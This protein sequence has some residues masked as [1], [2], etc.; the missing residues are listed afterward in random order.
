[1]RYH[2]ISCTLTEFRAAIRLCP[3]AGPCSIDE[4]TASELRD[5]CQELQLRD[6]I[7][8]ATITGCD[9]QFA[10]GR[11]TPPH[12]SA[13]PLPER[14]AWLETMGVAHSIAVLPM[15][16]IAILNGDAIA[17]GLELALATDLRIAADRALFGAG[18]LVKDGFPYDGASQRL[19]RLVGP[20]MALDLLLTGRV[21]S[22]PEALDAGL[23]NRVVP[24]AQLTAAADELTDSITS[25]APIA[26]RYA[27]EAV[28]AAADLTLAQ[29]LRLEADLSIILHSTADRAEGLASF[30]EKRPA[31]FAG[32]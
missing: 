6:E 16:V 9:D 13:A 28:A 20:A 32:R 24:A 10:V 17:H 25:A 21:L 29:G 19:P 8:V 27:K 23:V 22:A 18:S 4:D 7:R 14:L 11:R 31:R 1:M 2:K 30:A 3:T 26:S 5:C 12:L 15:P